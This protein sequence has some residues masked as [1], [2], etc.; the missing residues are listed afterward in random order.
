MGTLGKITRRTFLVASAAVAGGVLFGTYKY[1]QPLP[2]PLLDGDD[3]NNP[4]FASLN[5]YIKIDQSGVTIITPRAEMGQGVHSALA[6]MVAEELDLDW[7]TIKTEHGP[8]S[9]TY[10]VGV[11]LESIAGHQYD[12]SAM[13]T[14]LRKLSHVPAKFLGLQLTGGSTSTPDGFVKM[15]S[16]GA[17]ARIA[18]K[19]AAA[20]QWNVESDTLETVNGF[21]I[22]PANNEKLA[23]TELAVAA[24]AVDAP[25]SPPLRDSSRWRYMGK[26][27][28]RIDIPAKTKGTA[29][30]AI[31]VNRDDMLF[32]TVKMSPRFGAGIQSA[33]TSKAAAMNGVEKIIQL[34]SNGFAV[35]ANNT[36]RAF[37][38]ANAI[39]VEWEAA[40]Y[41]ADQDGIMQAYVDSFASEPNGTFDEKGNVDLVFADAGNNLVVR[42]HKLSMGKCMCG[43]VYKHRLVLA[44]PSWLWTSWQKKMFIY[45]PP[46]LVV[47]LV[48]AQKLTLLSWRIRLHAKPMA[49][50]SNSRGLV[51]KMS[52]MISTALLPSAAFKRL[53]M[54]QNRK[55]WMFKSPARRSC[56]PCRSAPLPLSWV[57][58]RLLPKVRQ[59]NQMT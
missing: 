47:V 2:N 21:V 41:P 43:R 38:A 9:T 55:H 25:D 35:I 32:A 31:D 42:W 6:M 51:K 33:D 11:M 29:E 39:E 56:F 45:I 3:A 44:M 36:W 53:W 7:K 22:N 16:A 12:H 50:L 34:D 13:T 28:P 5:P 48:D 54:T 18:L 15:R 14:R 52:A 4:D 37:K 26:S 58:T 49:G 59:V 23:Y 10:Y 24:A 46:I 1:K 27:V 20:E 57:Q 19:Q 30:F 8:A 17:S 40:S